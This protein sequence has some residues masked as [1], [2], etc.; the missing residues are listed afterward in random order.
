MCERGEGVVCGP[1]DFNIPFALQCFLDD[2][3]PL[4]VCNQCTVRLFSS[5]QFREQCIQSVGVLLK[6]QDAA[7]VNVS[8]SPIKQESSPANFNDDDEVY[9]PIKRNPVGEN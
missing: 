9:I 3:L 4:Q 8:L 1:L 6:I 7:L 2:G 5:L